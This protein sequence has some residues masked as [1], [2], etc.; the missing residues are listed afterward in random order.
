[1]QGAIYKA[2]FNVQAPSVFNCTSRCLWQET[3]VSLGF[4]TNCTDVTVETHATIQ[5]Y[6]T[7]GIGGQLFNMTTPGNITLT[8]GYQ[9]TS[10]LTL[11]QVAAVDL[12]AA[13]SKD[14]PPYSVPISS[15]FARMAVL[16]GA[17]DQD[18]DMVFVEDIYP[19]GWKVFECTVGLAA[20][21]YSN[22][23]ASGNQ[24]RI[25]NTTTI[26]LMS[27]Q[28]KSTM[29][30]FSQSNIP[31]MTIQGIDLGALNTFFTSSR[32]SGPT[33]SGEFRPGESTGVG[34][35]MRKA[36]VPTLFKAM[37]ESMTE[38]LRSGY[39]ITAEGFTV[40]SVV[41]VQVRWQWLSLPVFVLLAAACQ[42][43]YTMA[44]CQRDQRPLWKS[45]VV[46][47]LFHE[48][49]GGG[50]P[51]QVVRTKLQSKKQ[52]KVLARSTWVNVET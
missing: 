45:S 18:G 50:R 17:V 36:D 49:S 23:T 12:L 46:A 6:T 48:L 5:Q 3:Y 42:L 9:P 11:A 30:T 7:T 32:F 35:V 41:F 34:D 44:S 37:A 40:E 31:N 15:E 19:A 47:V 2:L 1:M 10:W 28:L 24:F 16:T 26:P 27:G 33:Y 52:L 13:Y 25:G 51:N 38:Q 22:I 29:M 14:T 39:N 20:Y 8:A 4:V 43:G 21:E